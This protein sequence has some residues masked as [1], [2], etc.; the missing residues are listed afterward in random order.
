[1]KS[2]VDVFVIGGG[3]AGLAAAIAARQQGLSV[4]VADGADHPIDKPCGEGLSPETLYALAGFN[5]HIPPTEGYRFRGIRFLQPGSE[6][7]ADF[8]LGTGIGIRRTILHE[9]LVSTAVASGAHLLW[10]IPVVGLGPNS[11]RLTTGS[12]PARWIIGADGGASRVRRWAGLEETLEKDQRFA[13]RRHYR[14][15]P[16]TDYVEVY[17]GPRTQGYVTP[18][19]REEICIVMMA[20][21]A[22]GAS[23]ETALQS[24]PELRARLQSAQLASRERGAISSLHRLK[25]VYRGNVALVGDA[26]GSFDAITGEGLRV[27]FAQALVLAESIKNSDLENYQLQ[28]RLLATRPTWMGKL[29]VAL[30]RHTSFRERAVRALAAHPDLFREFLELHAGHSTT[31]AMLATGAKVVWEFLAA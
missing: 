11:V 24:Y 16:W 23:F 3:P 13:S 20:D 28:H 21:T 31:P 29:L 6:V 22:P 18:I 12:V 9:L 26:S 1:M 4:I 5:I 17:W 8:P 25:N 14:V 10:R 2:P 30:G 7:A 15:K 19:S 27:A